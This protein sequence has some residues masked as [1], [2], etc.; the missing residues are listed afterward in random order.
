M[1][2]PTLYYPARYVNGSRC[3]VEFS[4][5]KA[6][7]SMARVRR[8]FGRIRD[9]RAR[10]R[11]ATLYVNLINAKLAEGWRPGDPDVLTNDGVL[12]Y[13]ALHA[14]LEIKQTFTRKRTMDTYKS[15][16]NIF[17][18]SCCLLF[19]ENLTCRQ[20]REKEARQIMDHLA[21]SRKL[22][23]RTYNNYLVDFK[24]WFNELVD[25]GHYDKNPFMRI[26]PVKEV[27]PE[28]RTFT[29]EELNRL[30][31]YTKREQPW[32]YVACCLCYYCAIRPNEI[33]SLKRHNFKLDKG[34]IT[35]PGSISK[36]GK[37]RHIIIAEPFK[38]ELVEL[39]DRVPKDHYVIGRGLAPGS[40][41]EW[42]Q[43]ISDHWREH[44]RIRL[45]FSSQL[46]FYGLKDTCAERLLEAGV[47]I[48]KIRDHF[49]HSNIAVTDA[50]L[51]QRTE[52]VDQA[53]AERFP[54]I[55]FEGNE[56]SGQQGQ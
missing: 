26:K 2:L 39:L 11:Q 17:H 40:V 24:G 42:S 1:Q 7:G 30:V 49:G 27:K 47:D 36:S 55:S 21:S 8:Y 5:E 19:G 52:Y 3:Y 33:V 4:Y 41:K 6:G 38:S 51:K 12:L 22:S 44:I 32:Y 25:R 10:H 15:R 18:Q 20:F 45:G 46:E 48:A 31:S 13:D 54:A 16:F 29:T 53:L 28:N 37:P 56:G 43:R 23:G 34:I 35:V 50:Y 14:Q 9:P